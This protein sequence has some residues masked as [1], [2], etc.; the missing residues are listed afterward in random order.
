MG[1]LQG[2]LDVI[3]LADLLQFIVQHRKV[4]TLTVYDAQSKKIL[5]FGTDGMMMLSTGERKGPRL[6]EMLLLTKQLTFPQVARALES[7]KQWGVHFGEA[8]VRLGYL[9]R[10][11]IFATILVQVEEE[12]CDMFVWTDASFTFVEGPP[13]AVFE[14]PEQPVAILKR[15]VSGLILEA[16][17]R[18][19]ELNSYNQL[20]GGGQAVYAVTDQIAARAADYA[21][22][23]VIAIVVQCIDGQRTIEETVEEAG[24]SRFIVYSVFAR[25]HQDGC[26]QRVAEPVRE[27]QAPPADTAA[28]PPAADAP[29]RPAAPPGVDASTPPAEKAPQTKRLSG[30]KTRVTKRLPKEPGGKPAELPPTILVFSPSPRNRQVLCDALAGAGWQALGTAQEANAVET[31]KRRPV[32][33]LLVEVPANPKAA[34]RLVADLKAA[35]SVPILVLASSK[36][37]DTY[38]QLLQA[39]ARECFAKTLPAKKILEGIRKNLKTTGG[40]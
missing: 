29:D 30:G 4:G 22:D 38:A 12:L 25:L 32:H 21:A 16:M 37:A 13:P 1:T 3:G 14:D 27:E 8:V 40:P 20:L 31:L 11:T 7:Q 10:E 17:R 19:D 23:P 9:P 34:R 18:V 2:D 35:T 39:G 28:E 15:D 5:H 6:G 33:L 24:V 26:L 36:S